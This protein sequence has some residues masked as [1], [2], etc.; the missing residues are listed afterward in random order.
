M[1]VG[2]F[3]KTPAERKRYTL[4][5]SNWLDTGETVTGSAFAITPTTASPFFIDGQGIVGGTQLLFYVNGGLDQ[6]DYLVT[7]SI[8]TSGGQTK[9]DTLTFNVRAAL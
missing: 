6:S 5:Y 8:T 3:T 1:K 4:D 7:V 9:Q 2:K